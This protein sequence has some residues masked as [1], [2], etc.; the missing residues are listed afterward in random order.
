MTGWATAADCLAITG[1]TPTDPILALAQSTIEDHC[2]RTPAGNDGM[3][4]RDL[5][6]LK[7]AVAYQ[8]AWLPSQP[9]YLARLGVAGYAQDGMSTTFRSA[10]DQTLAPLAQRALKNCSW[11]GT[12][13]LRVG[14]RSP[15]VPDGALAGVTAS[16]FLHAGADP[17]IGWEP[18]G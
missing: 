18:L 17:E 13:S 5:Y 6:W 15:R 2:N 16:T 8:A 9:G 10:A 11:M 3:R 1:I 12:R 14:S 7:K 4:T